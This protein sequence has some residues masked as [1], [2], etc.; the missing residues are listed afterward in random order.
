MHA[1]L[2]T[3]AKI[4]LVYSMVKEDSLHG[5]LPLCSW[6]MD[7]IEALPSFWDYC[8]YLTADG[9]SGYGIVLPVQPADSSYT[10]VA[11]TTK[12]FHVLGFLD[13][14]QRPCNDGLIVKE[15]NRRPMFPSVHSI[16]ECWNG[17]FKNQLRRFLVLCPLPFPGPHT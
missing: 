11:L 16:V 9:F 1:R 7:Y 4:W 3:P 14:L 17:S 15:F 5:T 8:Y 12:L 10:I 13:H 6:Q 2:V